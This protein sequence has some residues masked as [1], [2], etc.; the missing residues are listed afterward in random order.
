[1]GAPR[2]DIPDTLAARAATW[3]ALTDGRRLVVLLDDAMSAAQVRTLL[4]GAG[5]HLVLVTTRLELPGLVANGAH[6]L[7]P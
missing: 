1:M 2:W 6:Y 5:A 4:P 7:T 3:R